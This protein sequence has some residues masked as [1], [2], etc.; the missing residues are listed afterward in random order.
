MYIKPECLLLFG[1]NLQVLK[2]R[3]LQNWGWPLCRRL[4]GVACL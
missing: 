1:T 2:G 3:D 4:W